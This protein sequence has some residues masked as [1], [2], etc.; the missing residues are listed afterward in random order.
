MLVYQRVDVSLKLL[1]FP[2][3][4]ATLTDGIY[5]PLLRPQPLGVAYFPIQ[6]L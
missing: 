5:L 1:F 3:K 4:E 2:G 6:I